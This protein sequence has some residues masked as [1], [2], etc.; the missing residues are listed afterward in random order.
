MQRIVHNLFYSISASCECSN[1]YN[2]FILKLIFQV[3]F[4]LPS[5]ANFIP[6][7]F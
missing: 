5:V 3:A 1:I 6:V 4:K 7:S 2:K